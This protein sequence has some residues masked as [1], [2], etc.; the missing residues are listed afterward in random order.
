MGRNP[1]RNTMSGFIMEPFAIRP[2]CSW[3][4]QR[5][6]S[7]C[8][9]STIWPFSL[10]PLLLPLGKIVIFIVNLFSVHSSNPLWLVGSSGMNAWQGKFEVAVIGSCGREG[11]E[12]EEAEGTR[13]QL[14][15]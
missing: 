1:V 4:F 6:K 7:P 9:V 10:L 3:K 2:S 13:V 11:W 15:F 12:K 14:Q 8:P 5:R